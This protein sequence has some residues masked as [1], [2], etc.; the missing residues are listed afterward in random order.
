MSARP[1]IAGKDSLR[2]CNP[3][4]TDRSLP[5][6]DMNGPLW[7]SNTPLSSQPPTTL[8]RTAVAVQEGPAFSK[9]Q[10]IE[11]CRQEAIPAGKRDIPVIETRMVRIDKVLPNSLANRWRWRHGRSIDVGQVAR[12][13]VTDLELKF[14]ARFFTEMV[15]A[16]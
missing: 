5:H 10:F 15:P 2:C 4:R 7:K 6:V 8:S 11:K 13:G 9:R 3:C 14:A 12:V 1:P 16:W